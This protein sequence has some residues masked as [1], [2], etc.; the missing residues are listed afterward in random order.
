MASDLPRFRP[1][2]YTLRF[3]EVALWGATPELWYGARVLIFLV[4]AI[5]L[6]GLTLS[7][8][9]PM[10]SFGFLFFALSRTYWA[11]IFARLGP[12]EAYA[13][14]GFSMV[15]YGTARG[16]RH[17]WNMVAI[18]LVALGVAIAAGSKESFLF[19]AVLPIWL[20]WTPAI[21]LK[22]AQKA[23][24]GMVIAFSVWIA[25]SIIRRVGS[26]GH[27]VYAQSVSVRSR[28]ELMPN[29]FGRSDVQIWLAVILVA[30]IVS[31]FMRL[32]SR[33]DDDLNLSVEARRLERD[34]FVAS[35][36]LVIFAV[37]YVF[38]S[39]KWPEVL[40]PRYLFPGKLA[41]HFAI[42]IAVAALV[43]FS[44]L[45]SPK[46]VLAWLLPFSV[47]SIF[48]GVSV[49]D[50]QANRQVSKQVTAATKEFTGKLDQG[51]SFLKANPTYPVILHSHSVSDYEPIFAMERFVRAEGIAN[52]IAVKMS[53]YSSAGF[54]DPLLRGLARQ[55]EKLQS[56]GR[57]DGA[58]VPLS[59]VDKSK[60][61]Y[62]FG[63]SGAPIADCSAGIR[64]F[65]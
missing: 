11:D 12:A 33:R 6:C 7:V 9:G 41:E 3:S 29:F 28:L 8:A 15:A 47:T 30:M 51:R 43:R 25:A 34:M 55:I 5:V 37:Q 45:S 53:G 38:Y 20:L 56:T 2:Y 35:T 63:L 54:T 36:L 42:F 61:C 58:F 26:L 52:P 4:F 64:I 65:Q 14:L 31:G 39:G 17:G 1:S 16:I 57:P 44:Q 24:L 22:P 19:L 62:S 23:V 13:V 50:L 27:D 46:S 10:L 59:A 40:S 21:Q 60:A 49:V 48:L 18:L 32:L